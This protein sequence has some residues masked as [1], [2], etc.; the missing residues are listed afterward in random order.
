MSLKYFCSLW[1][2]VEVFITFQ[3]M[4]VFMFTFV[5]HSCVYVYFVFISVLACFYLNSELYTF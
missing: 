5:I 2:H 4:Y 1:F 3:C